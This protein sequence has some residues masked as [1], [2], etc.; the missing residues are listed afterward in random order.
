MIYLEPS[1]PGFEPC[2]VTNLKAHEA[3]INTVRPR[4]VDT[5]KHWPDSGRASPVDAFTRLTPE[6]GWVLPGQFPASW[7]T[8]RRLHTFDV[9]GSLPLVDLDS[10]ATH[11][12]L[13][14]NAASVLLQQGLQN[15]NGPAVGSPAGW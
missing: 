5:P 14:E 15:L 6:P 13:G 10:P 3:N 2:S 11:T 8:T 7:L 12:Q 9:I 1:C 4:R